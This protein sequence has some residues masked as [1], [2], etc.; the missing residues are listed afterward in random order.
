MFVPS[1]SSFATTLRASCLSAPASRCLLKLAHRSEQ[2]SSIFDPFMGRALSRGSI[3][4]FLRFSLWTSDGGSIVGG[5]D[6]I[7]NK[8]ERFSIKENRRAGA[9]SS[10]GLTNSLH[11]AR[12]RR[13]TGMHLYRARAGEIG[14]PPLQISRYTAR[15]MKNCR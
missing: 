14:T 9:I 8:R 1:R 10:A 3:S 7:R 11:I 4:S 6:R 2:L 5:G 12:E 15:G 13:D